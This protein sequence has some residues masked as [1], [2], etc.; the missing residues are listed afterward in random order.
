MLQRDA[1]DLIYLTTTWDYNST[2]LNVSLESH[3]VSNKVTRETWSANIS[4][5][6]K[7]NKEILSLEHP[8]DNEKCSQHNI[9]GW[10][11]VPYEELSVAFYWSVQIFCQKW[12]QSWLLAF[13]AKLLIN[14][15]FEC[16]KWRRLWEEQIEPFSGGH[17]KPLPTTSSPLLDLLLSTPFL[18]QRFSV[19]YCFQLLPAQSPTH[20][21]STIIHCSSKWS[22]PL[23]QPPSPQLT[24]L[25]SCLS[26]CRA[27]KTILSPS[28]SLFNPHGFLFRPPPNNWA[29]N[30]G[31]SK[32][33]VSTRRLKRRL[34]T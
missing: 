2:V 16:T 8:A 25:F 12:S 13:L 6:Q 3:P 9:G 26:V 24:L 7:L 32:N 29:T 34:P 18:Q 19:F 11:T 27:K 23:L 28:P 20:C 14:N 30:S 15:S 21:L 33:N 17:T 5:L 31:P 4:K 22:L 10:S 1:I